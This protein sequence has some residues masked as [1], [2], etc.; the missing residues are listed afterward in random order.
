VD[1]AESWILERIDGALGVVFFCVIADS[2]NQAHL[3]TKLYTERAIKL[4]KEAVFCEAGMAWC[5]EIG[6]LH[7]DQQ[8]SGKRSPDR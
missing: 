8:A 6:H 2:P 3:V 4:G 5:R 1:G 7:R